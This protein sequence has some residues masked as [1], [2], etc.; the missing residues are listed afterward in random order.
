MVGRAQRLEIRLHPRL[1][2]SVN[3]SVA[4][5][6]ETRI[7]YRFGRIDLDSFLRLKRLVELNVGDAD[8]IHRELSALGSPGP[9]SASNA[10]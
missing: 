1:T 2:I 5:V 9:G 10:L 6:A 7:G 8:E 3:G 4:H